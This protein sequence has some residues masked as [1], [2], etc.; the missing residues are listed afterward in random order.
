MDR[1][2]DGWLCVLCA[3]RVADCHARLGQHRVP[4]GTRSTKRPHSTGSTGIGPA[5][6]QRPAAPRRPWIP[7]T[8]AP[9]EV[10]Q[11]TPEA[12][13]DE[14]L[15][16]ARAWP[17]SSGLPP[18]CRHGAPSRACRLGPSFRSENATPR[19]MRRGRASRQVEG[20]GFAARAPWTGPP[21][22]PWS[23][24]LHVRSADPLAAAL[25]PSRRPLPRSSPAESRNRSHGRSLDGHLV[26]TKSRLRYSLLGTPKSDGPDGPHGLPES[27]IL[28]RCQAPR[29]SRRRCWPARHASCSD[30]LLRFARS[31]PYRRTCAP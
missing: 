8:A 18:R 19:R 12:F 6:L 11:G 30:S 13:Q 28:T 5:C 10:R 3:R 24:P 26:R 2:T 31:A 21:A 15:C 27:P 14:L 29:A 23:F 25:L 20:R 1:E 7:D 17:A 22:P 16:C 4:I 9:V